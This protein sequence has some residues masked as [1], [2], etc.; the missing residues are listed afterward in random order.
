LSGALPILQELRD[1]TR[2]RAEAIA[3]RYPDWPC[4]KGC[5]RCCRSLAQLP[6]L[7]GAEWQE[8]EAGLALLPAATRAEADARLSEARNF[9]A[10]PYTCPFLD[11]PEGACLIYEHRPIACRAYG[12]YVDERGMGLYCGIIGERVD[13]GEFSDAVWG[14]HSALEEKLRRAE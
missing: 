3:T 7:T 9:G 11:Q 12:F 4:R 6:D 13:A 2:D 1:A 5:D 8:V 14:N 10:A